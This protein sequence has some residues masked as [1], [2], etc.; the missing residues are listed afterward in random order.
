VNA[1]DYTAGLPPAAM[2]EPCFVR[3]LGVRRDTFVEFEFSIEDPSQ[4]SVEL[5]MPFEAFVGF[6]QRY[7]V[8][9]LE[10]SADAAAAFERLAWRHGSPGVLE[11]L[12]SRRS[13][14]NERSGGPE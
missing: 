6:C 4:L 14:A 10:P 3:L 11:R 5:V 8:E 1:D 2:N 12:A 13:E 7:S 9:L